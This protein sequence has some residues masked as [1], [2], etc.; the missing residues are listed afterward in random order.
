MAQIFRLVNDH[1]EVFRSNTFHGFYES[2]ESV[3]RAKARAYG[4]YYKDTNW[5]IQTAEVE[6]NELG[7]SAESVSVRPELPVDGVR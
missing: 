6:W 4:Y 7:G 2:I 3:E 5:R 1:N